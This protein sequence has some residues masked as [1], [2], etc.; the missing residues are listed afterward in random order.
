[1]WENIKKDPLI[2][3]IVVIILGVIAFGLAFNIMFGSGGSMEEGSM[4]MGTGYSLSNTLETI[5][6]LLIKVVIIGLL[7]GAVVWIFRAITKRSENNQVAGFTWIK[8]DPIIRNA[9]I[10]I[11]SVI[12]LVF[13]FSFLRGF[14]TAPG[15]GEGEM[16]AGTSYSAFSGLSFGIQSFLSLLLKLLLLISVLGL[17]Y[18]VIM[19]LREHY[20]QIN[21]VKETETVSDNNTATCPDCKSQLKGNW[22]CCPFCGSE[23]AFLDKTE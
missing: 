23:K 2:K 7:I 20:K 4:S 22:K 21:L 16:M 13:L 1:M 12:V 9:L 15:N 14:F 6:A 17:G 10:I 5:I 8:E 11:G 3:T 18:G 19:Y